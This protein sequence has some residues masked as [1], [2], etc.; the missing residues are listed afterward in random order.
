MRAMALLRVDDRVDDPLHTNRD[1]ISCFHGDI[2]VR[3]RPKFWKD[4]KNVWDM[5]IAADFFG[6]QSTD[7]C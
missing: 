2:G 5:L 7:V 4:H 1:K 3:G 6:G